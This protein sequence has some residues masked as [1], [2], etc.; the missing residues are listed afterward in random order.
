MTATVPR[1][2]AIKTGAAPLVERFA[3]ALQRLHT[4]GGP[5]GLAVSGGPDSLAMLLLAEAAIPG[6]FEVATVDHG[7]RPESA[8]EC[9]MVADICAARGIAC[10]V[11]PV[12]LATGNLYAEARSARYAALAKWAAAHGL[13]ALATAHHA[14]DQAETLLMRLNRGSGVQGL[15][16]VRERGLV[17][18]TDLPLIRPVL[19]FRREELHGV[20]KGAALVPVVDPSN[21][22]DRFDRAR[23]RKA[24][25][26]IDWI[27]PVALTAS[28]GHLA[29]AAEVVDWATHNEWTERVAMVGAQLHYR[30]RAEHPPRAILLQIVVRG[31]AYFGGDA[32]GGAAARLLDNLLAGQG[33]N[34]GGVMARAQGG[35]WIFS[36]EPARRN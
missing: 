25:Q 31:I 29:D 2:P 26:D 28:A 16:G 30:C 20:L 18:G 36:P 11:L 6:Q 8:A 21:S 1:L 19:Q 22:D 24:L 14:D 10:A 4:D 33:G 13:N 34:V 15:S 7:L 9:Q 5:L 35:K 32:R 23:I 17:P 27:D 12:Q 3:G